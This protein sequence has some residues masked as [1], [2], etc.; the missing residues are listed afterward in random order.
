MTRLLRR[1][2]RLLPGV[3]LSAALVAGSVAPAPGTPVAV[4]S[5]PLRVMPLGDSITLGI[6]SETSSSYRTDLYRRLTAAGQA[7]DLVG[8]Q[9]DGVGP[10][11][12]HEGHSGWTIDKIDERVEGWLADARPDVVLLHIG[13][14]DMRS[15][16][17]AVGAVGR[18]SQLIDRI[19]AARPSA[20]LVVAA[21]TGAKKS[22]E[23]RRIDAYN[24]G[25]R[26]VVA[27]KASSR[28]LL[29][30]QSAVDSLDIRD[31]LHPN[32]FGY[33][34]MAFTWFLALRRV[35]HLTGSTGVNPFAATK[36]RLCLLDAMYPG[37]VYVPVI[38]CRTWTKRPVG[39][40]VR[41]Q[42]QRYRTE[43]YRVKV[44]KQYTTRHRT[45]VRWSDS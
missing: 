28:V 18:L 34:K 42:T 35:L 24:R 26:A 38:E 31:N 4:T 27:A 8:S 33:T 36:A 44:G 15:D 32:D 40:S 3:C 17:K 20:H 14:N 12:D 23:Q 43:A 39:R 1:A 29:A 25:V 21:I 22:A 19:R 41:W 45:V 30:D 11:T 37:G 13:T 6:G 5:E 9:R 7:V 2:A 16:A 10:D